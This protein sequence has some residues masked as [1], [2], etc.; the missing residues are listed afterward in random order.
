MLI[1]YSTDAPLYHLPIATVALLVVNVVAFVPVATL[2][3]ADFEQHI[4]PWMLSHGDGLHPLQWI[5]SN[6]IHG[7]VLHL[8][9]NMFSLWAFGLVVEGKIGWWRFLLAYFGI[10]F[11]Q[12][13][14][15]QTIALGASGGGSF[16]A[17]AI[18]YGLMAIA[19][20]WAPRNE[21]SC[22]FLWRRVALFEIP[23]VSLIG[24]LLA[25]EV[26]TTFFVGM[27]LSSQVLHFMGA[28][29][30]FAVGAVMLKLH[31]VD[32]ENWDLFSVWA[33][34]N[35]QT[36]SEQTEDT[37]QELQKLIDQ[38]RSGGR[39][40]AP[41]RPQ[42]V[43]LGTPPP[44]TQVKTSLEDV[45][46][47]IADGQPDMAYRLHLAMAKASAKWTLPETELIR[48]IGTL[49][50]QGKWSESIPPMVEYVRAQ[51]PRESQVRLKLAQVL[52]ESQR[53]PALA[54][55]VLGELDPAV[56][57]PEERAFSLRLRERAEVL[58][59]EAPL[60]LGSE[61]W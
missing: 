36:L 13:A 47:L 4:V 3:A 61:D 46:R 22:L 56:L 54:L 52:I 8:L 33:G 1:P 45:R 7:G 19:L 53:R 20:V 44:V 15:E 28:G 12:C 6:F 60:E 17:S 41:A 31:W 30:G 34:R 21:I 32:C 27:T 10:G 14:L 11:V 25:I 9:G 37:H 16:G 59:E 58:R 49:Q 48:I 35:T 2:G 18:I 42:P 23:I 39:R 57:S 50:Q 29:L 24:I 51:G 55:R 5:A 38:E 26:V 40:P 43:P